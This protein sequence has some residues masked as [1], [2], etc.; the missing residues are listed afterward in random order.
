MLVLT[1]RLNEEI[2]IDGNIRI[3]ITA[4]SGEKVR[5]GISAPASVR[6]DRAEVHAVRQETETKAAIPACHEPN[7]IPTP[8]RPSVRSRCERDNY[9]RKPR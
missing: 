4:I 9:Q 2:I 8:T 7:Q 6:V 3:V 5:I 1:R